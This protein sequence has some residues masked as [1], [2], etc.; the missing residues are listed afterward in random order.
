MGIATIALLGPVAV[1][2]DVGALAPRDRV[3]LSALAVAP[4]EASSSER[5]ADA[6][7]GVEPPPSWPK[8]VPGCI[9]RLRRVIGAEFIETTPQG[10][11]LTLPGDEIDIRRFERLL[12]RGRELLAQSEPD[13]AARALADALALWRGRPVPD[14]HGWEPGRVEAERLTELRLDAQEYQ[15]DAE[16]RAG[17]H[18]DVLAR[19]K[20]LVAEAPL[21]ERRWWL[22]A[23]AQYRAGRQS[24]A[25]HTL[26]QARAMLVADLGLDPG[27]ELARLESDILRQDP[28]LLPADLGPASARCPY[29]GLVGYDIEDA[30]T[31]F[32][33]EWEVADCV[34]R[35]LD[36]GVLAVVG[37]S[38]SGKSSLVRAGVGAALG[39]DGHRPVVMT[40]GAHPMTAIAE[41]DTVGV[42]LIVD[43]FEE[44][45]TNCADPAEQSRFC[46]ELVDR[47]RLCRVVIAMRA[48][49]T[50][51][52]AAHPGLARLVERAMYLLGPMD[53]D[54]L[55]AA[56]TRPADQARLLLEPG[57]VDLLLQEVEGEP[58]ALPLLSHALRQTWERRTGRTLTVDGY[59]ATGGIRGCV[60]QTADDLYESI[61]EGQRALLRRLLLRLI[62]TTL[63]GEPVRSRVDR[64]SLLTDP[65]RA[66]MIDR[67]ADARLVT[68]DRDTVQIAH[69]CLARAWPR[70]AG[71]LDEDTEGQRIQRHLSATADA[72]SNLGRPDSDLYRGVR[73]AQAV[74]WRDSVRPALTTVE[75]DFLDA[76]V[77]ALETERRAVAAQARQRVRSRRRGRL[78][79]ATV[80]TLLVAAVVAAGLAV[81]QQR[82]RQASEEAARVTEAA[83][84]DDA[85]RGT[86][87]MDEA[88]LLAIEANRIDD[89][90]DTRSVLAALLSDHPALIRSLPARDMVRALAVSPDGG[91]LLVGEGDTGTSVYRTDTLERT[92]ASDLNGWSFRYRPDGQQV[93][94]TG[95]GSGGLG[96]AFNALSAAV[97]APDLSTP[98]HLQVSG[99]DG[100][101]LYGDDIAYSGDGRRVLVY[102]DGW[103]QR[104]DIV[105]SAMLFWDADATDRPPTV[106]RTGQAIAATL[107]ADG[108]ALYALTTRPSVEAIEV[109]TGRVIASATVPPLTVPTPVA[110]NNSAIDLGAQLADTMEISPDGGT[111]AVGEGDDIV[112]L[113]AT[114]LAERG[115]LRAQDRVLTLRFSHDGRRLAAGYVDHTAAVWNLATVSRT[116]L[117]TGHDAAVLAVAFSADDGTLYTGGEDRRVLVWDLTGRRR[118]AGTVVDPSLSTPQPSLAAASP[119]GRSVVFTGSAQGSGSVRFLDLAA[120]AMGAEVADPGGGPLVAWLPDSHA[121]VTA[122]G[123]TLRVRDRDSRR[124]TA[125]R[126][127][128]SSA[129]TA[130]T[131]TPD[132]AAVVAGDRTGRLWRAD[133]GSLAP[134]GAPISLGH[135]VTA[136]AAGPDGHAAALLDDGTYAWVE[137][138]AG[139]V[140]HTGDLGIKGTV[141]ALSPDGTAL[142]VGGSRG[143]VGLLDLT[144]QQWLRPP[145][146]AHPLY[147]VGAGFEADGGF[148]T[149]AFDGSL[150]LW[151]GT[152]EPVGGLQIAGSPAFAAPA[153]D[154]AGVLVTTT[155]GAVRTVD[156]DFASWIRFGC[157]VAGR[158]L[159]TMEWQG[160]FG[161]RDYHRSCGVS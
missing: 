106:V 30:Q 29:L 34:R 82:Q 23:L 89:S 56:I 47:A 147:V 105:D 11:R 104:L 93:L 63:D 154:G 139:T 114:T 111:V 31:F 15:V 24:E 127:V 113:D 6:L 129:V 161:D 91:T 13:D 38:G 59:R 58:G 78:V 123:R 108:S 69:E 136:V 94:L 16:I 7:W 26:R 41:H 33:R 80:A 155:D 39:R 65:A 87:D 142:V 12:R 118:L 8:V 21:R 95:R 10:Y 132:G 92:G 17:R 145:A 51:D 121:V 72:W 133:V 125:E 70:L 98:R 148:F 81:R 14:L 160:V 128:G 20:T 88:L 19:A 35:L 126:D 157:T 43:Q 28:S 36:V 120:G 151:S 144:D 75:A 103:S 76:G 101:W 45:F 71:W 143:E 37:P 73:L 100:Y 107:G 50:G 109:S 57:L 159:T 122:A 156:S 5:L 3:V 79:I 42:V 4:N 110:V 61:D 40:P 119:D 22:L 2:G 68:T 130:L 25:L 149:S 99:I 18:A 153:P 62:S 138:T 74:D 46:E 53:S 67:L 158:D 52:L 152:G 83:R 84:V 66:A 90:P 134:I 77:A 55:R 27:P 54:A 112:L 96:E 141:A 146:V 48:D 135:P 140:Q 137:L 116:E 97:A 102:A 115:R 150:R 49:R 64:Q 131:V 86:P 32:G 1:H 124:V 9:H 44:V 117:L 85:V 60:A